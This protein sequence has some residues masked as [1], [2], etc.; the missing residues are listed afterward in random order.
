LRALGQDPRQVVDFSVNLNPYGPP[1]SLLAAVER[2]PLTNYPDAAAR[3]AREAWARALDVPAERI[4]VGHGASDLFWA[5]ARALLGPGQRA[6]FAEPTFSELRVAAERTGAAVERVFTRD[7][8]NFAFDLD[9]LESAARGA[10]MLY[11]CSPNNPTGE[12]LSTAA[13]CRLAHALADTTIV[14]DQ[15]FL[16]L[17]EH[18][19]ERRAR[20]PDNVLCV[21]SLTKDFTLAGLRIAYLVGEPAL[22][23][24]IERERPTWATSAPALAAIEQ[25]ASEDAFVHASF[26]RMRNDRDALTQGL[27]ALGLTPLRSST[28]YQLV[29]VA[30]AP[31]LRARL[32]E[33]G[34]LVRDCS[35][36]G[37]PRHVRLAA[38][39]E[40]E[41]ARLLD[42]LARVLHA[43]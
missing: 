21:R 10:R 27:T 8:A 22:V 26:L 25:A 30:S 15:A 23:E 33:R 34:V 7:A 20:L 32:L 4:A 12:W 17:S 29:G 6:V 13:V 14:L 11:L 16:S 35:S 19:D 43:R 36:F 40:P 39:P 41:R 9:Q 28:G 5:L 18:A 38:R 24:R 3:A 42:A 1:S 2:A 31:V 37:L